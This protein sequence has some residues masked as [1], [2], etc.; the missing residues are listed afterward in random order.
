M[1]SRDPRVDAY[2][3]KA[4]PFAQP[5]LAHLREVVHAGCPEVV[6]T[7]KWSRPFFDFNGPLC[8]FAAFKAHCAFMFWKGEAFVASVGATEDQAM[9]QFGRL[10]RVADLPPKRTL[11]ALV[12]K[13][14]TL[15]VEGVKAPWM[16]ARAKKREARVAA[17]LVVPKD[18]AAALKTHRRAREA[19]EAFSP[20]HRREYI[21]WIDGA[22]RPETRARRLATTVE[23][24]VDGKTQN[25][26]Y[27]ARAKAD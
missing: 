18:L 4:A 23:Q 25:W 21:E 16:E 9:G 15:N 20:S 3:S 7:I 5:I 27:E 14:A 2:I 24:L 17:P 19:F 10:T 1:G 6:E 22:K 26:K 13:A 11:V 12:K 8:G